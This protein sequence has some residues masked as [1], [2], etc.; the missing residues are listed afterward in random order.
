MDEQTW[1]ESRARNLEQMLR[2][3]AERIRSLDAE[4]LLLGHPAELQKL[5]G[6]VRTELFHYEVRATYDTPEVAESRR[7]VAD[8]K[9]TDED[10]WRSNPW[11]AEEGAADREE[12]EER[13]EGGEEDGPEDRDR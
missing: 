12:E 5:L 2:F 10:T 9:R 8:A 4:G 1:D 7:I 11:T 6:D 3:L 13:G